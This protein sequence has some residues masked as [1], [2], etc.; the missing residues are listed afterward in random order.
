MIG[1]HETRA[2]SSIYLTRVQIALLRVGVVPKGIAG[3]L[4]KAATRSSKP[5]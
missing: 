4:S 5:R 2:G 3:K 1:S